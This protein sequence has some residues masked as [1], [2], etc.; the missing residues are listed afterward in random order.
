MLRSLAPCSQPLPWAGK[1]CAG[2]LRLQHYILTVHRKA[3][4]KELRLHAF[5]CVMLNAA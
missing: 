5:S 1:V 2:F 4:D 3:L